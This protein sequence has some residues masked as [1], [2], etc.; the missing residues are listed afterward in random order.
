MSEILLNQPPPIPEHLQEGWKA[1]AEWAE[2]MARAGEPLPPGGVFVCNRNTVLKGCL[3]RLH[4]S[5]CR[6][7]KMPP[8]CVKIDVERNDFGGIE[9]RVDVIPPP[10]WTR[11]VYF[12]GK[13][14]PPGKRVDEFINAYIVGVL[15][16]YY[17]EFRKD[18]E[19]RLQGLERCARPDLDPS[20]IEDL[21]GEAGTDE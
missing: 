20:E 16:R 14:L 11:N 8:D 9:P 13:D 17:D 18:V 19:E 21:V 2:A 5:I 12:N 4:V 3:I 10:G 7:L 6:E 15:E 1:Y